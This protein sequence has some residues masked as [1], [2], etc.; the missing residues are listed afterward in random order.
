ML[1]G[2]IL[3]RKIAPELNVTFSSFVLS[4]EIHEE[5]ILYTFSENCLFSSCRLTYAF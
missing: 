4:D 3:F 5:F 2:N 1:S